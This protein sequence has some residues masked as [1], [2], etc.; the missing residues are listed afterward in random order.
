MPSQ[1]LPS[2]PSLDHLKYQARDLLKSLQSQETQALAR[3]REFHPKVPASGRFSLSDAQLILAREYGFA[4][5]TR[6]RQFVL[7]RAASPGPALARPAESLDLL[8]AQFLELAC[9]DHHVRGGPAHMM[10]RDAALQLL[11]QHPEI[12]RHSL[13]T[14]VVC[15]E[16]DLVARILKER[17]KAA[18]EKLTVPGPDRSGPGHAG[19]ALN[20]NGP[21]CWDPLLFLCFTRLP[22]PAVP[23]NSVEIA[24]L[25]L[26]HGADPNTY[27]KA[28]DSRYTPLVGVI[29]EGEE[30]RPAHPH[31]DALT[32]LLLE[33]DAEPY[34]MQVVYNIHFQGRILWF[35]KLMHEHSVRRGRQADWQDPEWSM[36]DMGGYGSGARW[37]LDIAVKNN[38]LEL[39]DWL[40]AHGASPNAKPARDR[41]FPQGALYKEAWRRGFSE[42]A[43]LLARYGAETPG[44]VIDPEDRFLAACFRLDKVELEGFVQE[45][46]QYLSR[47]NALMLAAERDRADVAEL[48]LDLGVSPNIGDFHNGNQRPLHV[49]A[50]SD[51]PRVAEVLIKR[52]AEIDPQESH[53]GATPLSYAIWA[54]KTRM[55]ELL[56]PLSRS[57]WSLAFLGQVER[58][59]GILHEQP[60]LANALT[61]DGDTP[62]MRLPGDE[63]LAVAITK[64]LLDHG[65]DPTIKNRAG[66]NAATLARK[67]RLDRAADLLDAAARQ[68]QSQAKA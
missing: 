4:S 10:A 65:A 16:L 66:I 36:L 41:R 6:L 50:Y 17:P 33:R 22:I 14:A 28:G 58:L 31:R 3:A 59:R 67:R 61:M 57:V 35:M 55:I 53:Y 62:L 52:G 5:W 20:D 1:S 40:L 7:D 18:A 44:V 46:P 48:L 13:Y 30:S 43:A 24:R 12:A 47:P 2:N 11:R 38:D 25:L 9:P 15:G 8:A 23:E 45:H 54:Q 42:M 34:D 26:D 68:G 19:D 64:L 29:G 27:F 51:S 21:K 60:H 39:A 37:H 63:Q 49:C 32:R 56:A